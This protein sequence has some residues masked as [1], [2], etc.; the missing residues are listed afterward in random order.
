MEKML[1]VSLIE[2]K[3]YMEENRQLSG[4]ERFGLAVAL[5]YVIGVLICTFFRVE[6]LHGSF[7]MILLPSLWIS[8]SVL[9]ES[10]PVT[11]FMR[12]LVGAFF[13]VLP[14]IAIIPDQEKSL[15]ETLRA[16]LAI[17]LVSITSLL[18][19]AGIQSGRIRRTNLL[20]EY[21]MGSEVVVLLGFLPTAK[22]PKGEHVVAHGRVT[23]ARYG[24]IEVEFVDPRK[25]NAEPQK[26]WF[27][28]RNVAAA[29]WKI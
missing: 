6:P 28:H 2:S 11:Y 1:L 10:T 15:N 29:K 14:L 9:R 8:L 5:S 27:S 22:K 16:G 12:C 18:I 7:V 21:P 3:N 23:N 13:I 17:I 19:T 4:F 25:D 24:H 20:K 26:E